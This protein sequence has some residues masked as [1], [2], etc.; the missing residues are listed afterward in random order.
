M[1]SDNT[2]ITLNSDYGIKKNGSLNSSLVFEFNSILQDEPDVIR[3]NISVLNA[4]IPCSFY[5]IT[6]SNNKF[7]YLYCINSLQNENVDSV[8]IKEG[9]YNSISLID[10]LNT[11]FIQNNDIFLKFSYDRITGKSSF[12]SSNTA[13]V[14]LVV[15]QSSMA[16]V[17]GFEMYNYSTVLYSANQIIQSPHRMNLLGVKRISIH[18]QNINTV[19]YSSLN[20]SASTTLCTINN[21][22]PMNGIISYENTDLKFVLRVS[23][24]NSIDIDLKDENQEFLDFHNVPWTITLC[25]ERIRFFSFPEKRT[26]FQDVV[27]SSS[28]KIE[29]IDI[30]N[31]KEVGDIGDDDLDILLYKATIP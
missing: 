25:L 27:S 7:N 18:S 17:L 22:S 23:Q 8:V 11:G 9:N 5:N 20:M 1:Y 28:S 6:S 10:A 30:N 13:L 15:L 24:I 31:L 2:L 14:K 19:S 3:C 29:Q 4:M 12:S 16:S 21:D 26:T